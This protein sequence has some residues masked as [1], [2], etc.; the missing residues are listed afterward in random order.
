MVCGN[1]AAARLV[2]R[3][4]LII[5]FAY[6]MLDEKELEDFAPRVV[7]VDTNNFPLSRE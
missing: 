4:D 6:G 1:G 3:G 7:Q 5:I 2:H